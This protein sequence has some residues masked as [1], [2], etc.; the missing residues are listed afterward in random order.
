MSL[1][2]EWP[3]VKSWFSTHPLSMWGGVDT[4]SGRIVDATHPQSGESLA[5]KIVVLP[6]G[7]GS[8][9]SS[10]VL[11][12]MLRIGTGPAGMILEEPD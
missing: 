6:S 11:A 8:S 5:G 1:L 12:E 7:R 4:E 2:T 10:S 9:S 3:P